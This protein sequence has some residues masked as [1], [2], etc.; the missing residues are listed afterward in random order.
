[1]EINMN[2]DVN[3]EYKSNGEKKAFKPHKAL[4]RSCVYRNPSAESFS[5]WACDYI[6]ITGH[7]RGCEP[8]NC[9]KYKRDAAAAR[10]YLHGG[11]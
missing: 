3:R 5:I 1:M 9:K 6:T 8:K 10:A 11:N 7:M 2:R 4:C